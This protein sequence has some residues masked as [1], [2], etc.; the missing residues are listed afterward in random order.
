MLRAFLEYTLINL[1]LA[2][3]S[4]AICLWFAP[5]AVG[6]GLPEVKAYLNGVCVP[7]FAKFNVFLAKI[8]ATILSVTSGLIVGPEGPL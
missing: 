3:A 2:L 6:S 7:R 8:F 5:L 4:S 1:S